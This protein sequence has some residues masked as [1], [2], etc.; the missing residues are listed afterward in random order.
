MGGLRPI[1]GA[2]AAKREFGD[3]LA[4]VDLL[5]GSSESL[6]TVTNVLIVLGLRRG[7]RALD[8]PREPNP[9]ALS[10]LIARR[11]LRRGTSH[12]APN[13]GQRGYALRP[14]PGVSFRVTL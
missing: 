2:R 1:T 8:G 14:Q 4:N 12:P 5:H 11:T 13:Y 7:L 9:Y 6:L 3:V 10:D